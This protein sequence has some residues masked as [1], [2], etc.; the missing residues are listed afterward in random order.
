MKWP[1]VMAHKKEKAKA[2]GNLK[3]RGPQGHHSK[4]MQHRPKMAKMIG[5][6]SPLVRGL[7]PKHM[8]EGAK[9]EKIPLMR[10][11]IIH[12]ERGL[13]TTRIGQTADGHHQIGQTHR[14]ALALPQGVKGGGAMSPTAR[15]VMML[16]G[17][18]CIGPPDAIMGSK[19]PKGAKAL[20][21]K[22]AKHQFHP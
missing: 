12:R 22:G 17:I 11:P 5:G 14:P 18:I 19:G 3:I 13:P 7:L 20:T 1:G 16:T 2:R 21:P 4:E 15:P 8:A 6:H 10:Q 9:G